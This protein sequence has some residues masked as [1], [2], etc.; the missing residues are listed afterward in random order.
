MLLNDGVT[1]PPSERSV[2]RNY[3]SQFSSKKAKGTWEDE[4][5]ECVARILGQPYED[6]QV[7]SHAK[8]RL[9]F[10]SS[11]GAKYSGLNMG[12]GEKALFDLVGALYACPDGSLILIDEIELGL[13]EAAQRRLV[14]EASKLCAQKKLQIICTT[15]SPVILDSLPPEGRFLIVPGTTQTHITPG[16]TAAY[17]AGRLG[18]HG[19]DEASI[20]VEDWVAAE[21]LRRYL[22]RNLLARSRIV[23]IGS[24]SAIVHQMAARHQDKQKQATIAVMDG[25]QRA[26]LEAHTKRFVGLVGGDPE[27]AEWIKARSDFLPG[28]DSPERWVLSRARELDEEI[29]E[30]HFHV[31]NG[32]EIHAA[33]DHALIVGDH[34]ELHTFANA[35]SVSQSDAWRDLCQI[36]QD[37]FPDALSEVKK[38]IVDHLKE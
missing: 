37:H 31:E 23:P 36:V 13:H 30:D 9:H 22:P 1:S 21:L 34:R 32:S 26:A 11:K 14:A 12:A 19:S 7:H 4:T 24:H 16:I 29:L 5:R 20:Y 10:V 27:K 8:Y 3:R 25:D 2:F 18:E 6:F 38:K 28:D 35:V 33:L 15:H 17:A